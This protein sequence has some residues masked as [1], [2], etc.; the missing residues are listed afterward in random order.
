MDEKMINEKIDKIRKIEA[1]RH[2]ATRGL[3][4]AR[5]EMQKTISQTLEPYNRELRQLEKELGDV[6]FLYNKSNL[7]DELESLF[8]KT[9]RE[10][11]VFESDYTKGKFDSLVEVFKLF[12]TDDEIKYL[13]EINNKF[14]K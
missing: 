5:D 14:I 1:E 11:K 13:I 7:K 10:S 3:F 6:Y 8:Y 12:F 2:N 4:N 9:H